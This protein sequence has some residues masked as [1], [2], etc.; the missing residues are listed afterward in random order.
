LRACLESCRKT[1]LYIILAYDNPIWSE[2]QR[3]E[4]RFPN[5]KTL[6]LVDYISIK[7][8]TWGSG[9]GIPHSWN[10]WYGMRAVESLGFKYVF[11]I[12]G[13]CVMEKPEGLL[14]LRE[15][16]GNADAIS[17]EYVKGRYFGTMA[18][19]GKTEVIK[20]LWDMNMERLYQFNIGNAEGR[21]GRFSEQLGLKI[22]PV[23]N[24]E[25]HH[26]KPPGTRGTF[27]KVLG[28]RHLH[29]E[30]KVRRWNRMKPIEMKYCEVEYLNDFERKTLLRYWNG[31]GEKFLNSWWNH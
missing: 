30:H 4:K 23:E 29:A 17:C 10:L 22:V 13:D 31:E 11:N 16:L 12:N 9:V 28:F 21:L 7:H 19:L 25:D 26:F 24:P 1:A 6:K 27:R 14:K 3:I 20:N 15:M 5:S 18:Y 2:K 8:K